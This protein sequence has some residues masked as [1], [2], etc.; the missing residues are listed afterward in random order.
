MTQA[1][2]DVVDKSRWEQA[3]A[4]LLAEEKAETKAR[5]HVS[6][7]RRRLPM[8]RVDN[9][10]FEGANGPVT[11]AELFDG[12]SQLIVHNFMFDPEWDVGCP[13]C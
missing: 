11:L 7:R 8:M 1:Y 13:S 5:D 2:P 6:A 10:V 9:Y 4:D 3:R 12:R